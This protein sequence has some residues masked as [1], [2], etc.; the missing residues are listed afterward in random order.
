ML[1]Q[2]RVRLEFAHAGSHHHLQGFTDPA[3]FASRNPKKMV[4]LHRDPRD[5]VVSAYFQV[6]KRAHL[7][8]GSMSEFIRSPQ[9]GIERIARFNSAWL[10]Y[11]AGN[12]RI[13]VVSYEQLHANPAG[14]LQSICRFFDRPRTETQIVRAV[15]AGRFDVMHAGEA[16]GA[17]RSGYGTR[18]ATANPDDPE[19][20]KVRR[21]KIGGF[22]DYL[23]ADDQALCLSILEGLKK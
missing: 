20:F 22:A 19:S 8:D 16:V 15:A 12:S 21:G 11:A 14:E 10:R 4:F 1:D 17:Y 3:L 23:S 2:L 13:H 5:M 6:T 18:L 7:F 9:F